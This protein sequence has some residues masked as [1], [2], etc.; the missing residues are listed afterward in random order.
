MIKMMAVMVLRAM[1]VMMAVMTVIMVTVLIWVGGGEGNID[2]VAIR[3]VVNVSNSVYNDTMHPWT[4][5]LALNHKIV[6]L[7]RE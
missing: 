7:L 5:L 1:M 4:Q 3:D 6:C 2:V